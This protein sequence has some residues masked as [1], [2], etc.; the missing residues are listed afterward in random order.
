MHDEL[1]AVRR[2]WAAAIGHAGSVGS[3]NLR[4]RPSTSGFRPICGYERVRA[5]L[6]YDGPNAE[7]LA[8][9]VIVHR[10]Q[11]SLLRDCSA[12]TMDACAQ[13]PVAAAEPREAAEACPQ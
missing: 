8:Y 1:R 4:N 5:R 11:A 13:N 6:G 12:H 3:E 9:H 10:E 2:A 7:C